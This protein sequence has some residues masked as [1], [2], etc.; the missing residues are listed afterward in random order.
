MSDVVVT[1]PKA[2]WSEWMAEGDRAYAAGD[3]V[4][5]CGSCGRR[6]PAGAGELD[7]PCDCLVDYE[8]VVEGPPAILT[9]APWGR[10]LEYGWNLNTRFCPTI[11]PGERVYVV[12]HGRLRGYAPLVKVERN[13]RRFGQPARFA[14]VRRG[15]AVACTIGQPIRGFQGWRYRWWGREVELPFPGWRAVRPRMWR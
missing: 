13:T 8:P 3:Q 11:L 14:L 1:V 10:D 15:D 6:G 5:R 9:P 7:V 4:V 2:L 12:A